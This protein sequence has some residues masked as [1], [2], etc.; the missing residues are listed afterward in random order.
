MHATDSP[1]SPLSKRARFHASGTD[2]D[3]GIDVDVTMYNPTPTSV[4]NNSSTTVPTQRLHGHRGTLTHAF[5]CT[6]A[7]TAS[8][9][10][11]PNN[12]SVLG[13]MPPANN[14]THNDAAVHL[15]VSLFNSGNLF[16]NLFLY[17]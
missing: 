8:P 5:Y 9:A 13:E 1:S 3:T 16:S 6:G 17:K 4:T 2:I 15:D 10:V 14:E 7:S 11:L 12:F